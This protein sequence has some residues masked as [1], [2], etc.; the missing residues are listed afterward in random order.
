MGVP[1]NRIRWGSTGSGRVRGWRSLGRV[2]PSHKAPEESR[3][4]ILELLFLLF[5]P[6][7]CV[8]L[9][10]LENSLGLSPLGVHSFLD[11]AP[12]LLFCGR[13]KGLCKRLR[14]SLNGGVQN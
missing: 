1:R 5:D 9:L 2:G 14:V 13:P 6:A 8:C 10:L 7:L 12:H 3:S 11:L 4:P